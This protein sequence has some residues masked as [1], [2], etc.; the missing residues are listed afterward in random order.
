MADRGWAFLTRLLVSLALT[1]VVLCM[2]SLPG[3]GSGG[4]TPGGAVCLGRCTNGFPRGH[5]DYVNYRTCFQEPSKPDDPCG[6]RLGKQCDWKWPSCHCEER[7][8]N[9]GKKYCACASHE[10]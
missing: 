8:D 1:F 3:C 5:K 2:A 6:N 9:E 4:Q 7:T 10:D